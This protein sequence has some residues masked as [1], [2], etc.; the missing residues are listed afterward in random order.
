MIFNRKFLKLLQRP[1]DPPGT[2]QASIP[3]TSHPLVDL[4]SPQEKIPARANAYQ[5]SIHIFQ[6]NRKPETIIESFL[7]FA[8]TLLN[9]VEGSDSNKSA[10]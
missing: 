6:N 7:A 8:F 4:A 1:R 9:G 10:F 5:I 3:L 2:P